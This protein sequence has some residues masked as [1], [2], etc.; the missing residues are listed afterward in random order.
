MATLSHHN[1]L[2]LYT[3]FQQ[4]CYVALCSCLTNTLRQHNPQLDDP[5]NPFNQS[6][7]GTGAKQETVETKGDDIGNMP[8]GYVIR[9][10]SG[11]RVSLLKHHLH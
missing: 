10:W 5:F 11:T 4:L 2:C 7:R 9:R 6:Q 3:A 1:I 8:K